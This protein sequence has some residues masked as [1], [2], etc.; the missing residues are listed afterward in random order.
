MNHGQNIPRPSLEGGLSTVCLWAILDGRS[1]FV[2][3]TYAQ[4]W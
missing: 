1:S 2:V 4:K 3:S